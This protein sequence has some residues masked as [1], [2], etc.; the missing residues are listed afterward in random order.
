MAKNRN[1]NLARK[2]LRLFTPARIERKER[3][4]ITPK[5]P[6]PPPFCGNQTALLAVRAVLWGVGV[7]SP[8][9]AGDPYSIAHDENPPC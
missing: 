7:N 3:G 4:A 8:R 2:R 6:F 1:M 5:E 9:N